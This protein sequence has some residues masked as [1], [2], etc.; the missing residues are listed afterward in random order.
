MILRDTP[1][2]LHYFNQPTIAILPEGAGPS[3]TASKIAFEKIKTL[4][5][6]RL[7]IDGTEGEAARNQLL[8][9]LTPAIALGR[10]CHEELY[11]CDRYASMINYRYWKERTV[12]E[13]ETDTINARRHFFTGLEQFHG[14]DLEAAKQEFDEGLKLWKSI[15]E[16]YQRIHDDDITADETV[17]IVRVY[18]A[19]C[20]QLDIEIALDELPFQEYLRKY[21]QPQATPEEYEQM[22]SAV[23]D[24]ESLP[25]E[26]AEQ[27]KKQLM[28]RFGDKFKAPQ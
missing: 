10:L 8:E 14:G 19:V 5:P 25:P 26:E 4:D 27:K 23:R 3:F 7:V 1:L 21:T 28:E 11:W 12:A 18:H 16:K 20:Q 22:R 17:K 9:F 2:M 13:S 6:S 15:L 24:I